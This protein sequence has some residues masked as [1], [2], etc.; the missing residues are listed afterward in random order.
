MT[1][2]GSWSWDCFRAGGKPRRATCVHSPE[3][4]I[5]V[6]AGSIL[7]R[8]GTT[9][10]ARA[11]LQTRRL[12]RM[13]AARFQPGHFHLSRMMSFPL[14]A[15]FG[16]ASVSSHGWQPANTCTMFLPAK[17]GGARG[18]SSEGASPPHRCGFLNV[19][20]LTWSSGAR[21]PRSC[22]PP[23]RRRPPR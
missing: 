10:I 9:G 16:F 7:V 23:A 22:S 6:P 3:P 5:G 19:F 14:S 11:Q 17:D 12:I 21:A 15:E 1:G 2:K 4:Q 20:R 8:T 18:P 13:R